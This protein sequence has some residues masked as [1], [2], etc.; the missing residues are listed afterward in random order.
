M[1]EEADPT[2]SEDD[3]AT[4]EG[5][6]EQPSEATRAD[7]SGGR[8]LAYLALMLSCLALAASAW[9]VWSRWQS[10]SSE[11]V[12]H[13]FAG[14]DDLDK[15]RGEVEDWKSALQRDLSDQSGRQ[16]TALEAQR[17]ATVDLERRL[18]A[19]EVRVEDVAGQ[20]RAASGLDEDL[21]E[22]R[23]QQQQTE[24]EL[25]AIDLERGFHDQD[26]A[27]GLI[28]T[29]VSAL[30]RMGQLRLELD[31]D[32][33]AALRAYQEAG[34]LLDALADPRLSRIRQRLASEQEDV[35]AIRWP[36]WAG[37]QARVAGLN[38]DLMAWPIHSPS[39]D[40]GDDQTASP[41]WLSGLRSA[42]SGLVEI[43]R[44]APEEW[45]EARLEPLRETI[46]LRVLALELALARRDVATARDYSLWLIEAIE[47][48]FQVDSA[49][50]AQVLEILNQAAAINPPVLPESLGGS[51]VAI[52]RYLEAR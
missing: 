41:G 16:Q 25:K 37:V 33:D 17:Q 29:E 51:R 30:L 15:L 35:A 4:A 10:A 9:L 44:T 32:P 19:L 20:A 48:V 11:P 50:V 27:Q 1:N 18:G 12:S 46:R 42:L 14:L 34:R 43:R 21:A 49:P 22:L 7:R 28:L 47:R 31:A 23:A 6:A 45:T 2:I 38:L 8:G 24:A 40:Q 39:P 13:S 26:L 52:A 3:S 5:A 36:D